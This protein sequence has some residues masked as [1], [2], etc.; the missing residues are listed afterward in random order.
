MK[1]RALAM[2]IHIRGISPNQPVTAALT[3]ATNGRSM[4]RTNSACKIV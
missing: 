3:A 4:V 2:M 1:V